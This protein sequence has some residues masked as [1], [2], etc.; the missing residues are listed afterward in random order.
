M[1]QHL[2]IFQ[3][4]WEVTLTTQLMQALTERIRDSQRDSGGN[5]GH[6]SWISDG[7][8][9][10]PCRKFSVTCKPKSSFTLINTPLLNI[11]HMPGLS[12]IEIFLAHKKLLRKD[13]PIYIQWGCNIPHTI[14]LPAMAYW[15]HFIGWEKWGSKKIQLG[16]VRFK[17]HYAWVWDS[18]WKQQKL[19]VLVF[20]NWDHAKSKSKN[21]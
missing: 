18:C 21:G 15:C 13:I 2:I 3:R 12:D 10:S 1:G 16:R 19:S 7:S 14:I 20:F 17:L 5:L 6:F 11:C 8:Q 4:W 9:L